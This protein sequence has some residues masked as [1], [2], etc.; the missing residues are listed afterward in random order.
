MQHI[1]EAGEETTMMAGVDA[2]VMNGNKCTVEYH[3][4]TYSGNVNQ[5]FAGMVSVTNIDNISAH[6]DDITVS[7]SKKDDDGTI[8]K[9]MPVLHK[10][11]DALNIVY[12]I[13]AI[14]S[15]PPLDV[16]MNFAIKYGLYGIS[17]MDTFGKFIRL[18]LL[19]DDMERELKLGIVDGVCMKPDFKTTEDGEFFL[20]RR[21]VPLY[22]ALPKKRLPERF[23]KKYRRMFINFGEKWTT[24]RY[25]PAGTYFDLMF[26]GCRPA[27]TNLQLLALSYISWCGYEP[28]HDAQWGDTSAHCAMIL[29][30]KAS[31]Q[32]TFRKFMLATVCQDKPINASVS[33]VEHI[34]K[35]AISYEFVPTANGITIVQHGDAINILHSKLIKK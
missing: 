9:Y 23:D 25:E 15:L 1:G 18:D 5:M 30:K 19:S 31:D 29:V 7:F 26:H 17:D 35:N 20:S 13:T 14:R 2:F 27:H 10:T 6:D 3:G 12:D 22:A 28:M 11:K 32:T 34:Q 33:H 24:G 8:L 16:L 21:D 4:S